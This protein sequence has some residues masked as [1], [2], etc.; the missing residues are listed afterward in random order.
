MLRG[1]GLSWNPEKSGVARRIHLSFTDVSIKE[2]RNR[3][4]TFQILNSSDET[5]TPENAEELMS[6]DDDEKY[7]RIRHDGRSHYPLTSETSRS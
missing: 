7:Q 4:Q 2:S 3:R 6:K 5:A 1:G